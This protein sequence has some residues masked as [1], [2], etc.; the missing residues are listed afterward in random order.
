MLQFVYIYI[1]CN[2]VDRTHTHTHTHTHHH[3]HHTTITTYKKH[4]H[5]TSR[6][7]LCLAVL[8][9][10]DWLN[11]WH[12]HTHT[13]THTRTHTHTHT[14]THTCLQRRKM[15][16]SSYKHAQQAGTITCTR[17]RRFL[18]IHKA[19]KLFVRASSS[20]LW[21]RHLC[22]RF[23][24]EIVRAKAFP[25]YRHLPNLSVYDSRRSL[26]SASLLTLFRGN[27]VKVFETAA[28]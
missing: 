27:G 2:A 9:G 13:H 5:T 19:K 21:V 18:W 7:L 24:S 22:R 17:N 20:K 26:T 3:H 4:T 6:D 10:P 14:H 1:E 16:K 15:H 25:C 11:E 8:A 12:T 23:Q 28:I